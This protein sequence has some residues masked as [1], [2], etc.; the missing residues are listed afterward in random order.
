MAGGEFGVVVKIGDEGSDGLAVAAG[1][2]RGG[3]DL[4]IS[5][6]NVFG[7]LSEEREGDPVPS[8]IPEVS[9]HDEGNQS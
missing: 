1:R 2:E 3:V 8:C 7:G 4:I 9:P 5:S 6:L